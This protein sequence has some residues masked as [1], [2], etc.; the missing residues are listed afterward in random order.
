MLINRT[1][2]FKLN[3][4]SFWNLN[5]FLDMSVTAI[6]KYLPPLYFQISS[7]FECLNAIEISSS[8]V[9]GL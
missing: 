6:S 1:V 8:N 4:N 7:N 5:M 2:S 3:K 9:F